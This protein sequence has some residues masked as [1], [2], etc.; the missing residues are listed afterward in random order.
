MGDVLTGAM[1]A[2][3]AQAKRHNLTVEDAVG[4]AVELH[5]TAGERLV[6][7]GIGP[8][9]LTPSELLLEIRNLINIK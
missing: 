9:G 3:L 7:R 5:A 2:V 4:L 1:A 8:I 6:T